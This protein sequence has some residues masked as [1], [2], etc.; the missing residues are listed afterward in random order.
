MRTMT[1]QLPPLVVTELVAGD[2][3]I[4]GARFVVVY[5]WQ[6]CAHAGQVSAMAPGADGAAAS[7]RGQALTVIVFVTEA[8]P[9]E[10][11]KVAV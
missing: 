4:G 1:Q 11:T 7:H 3:E 9:S 8:A 2:Q 5:K 10:A 6:F